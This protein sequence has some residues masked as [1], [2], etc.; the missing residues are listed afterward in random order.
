MVASRVCV[1]L[2]A[3]VVVGVQLSD[4]TEAASLLLACRV[5][6]LRRALLSFVAEST[7]SY[8]G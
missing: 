1:V 2:T 8:V 7:P 3:G 6:A 5:L 4:V